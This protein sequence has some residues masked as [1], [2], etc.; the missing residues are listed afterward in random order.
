MSPPATW[1]ESAQVW[2]FTA[3]L[4]VLIVAACFAYYQ[5]REARRLREQQIRP[6]V[7]I[8]FEVEPNLIIYLE[9]TNLGNALARDV[10]IQ[11]DPPLKSAVDFDAAGLKM[12][13]EGITTLAPGK[14]Y[15][16]FFDQGNKRV[17][18]DLPMNYVAT[19]TYTDQDRKRPFEERL[20]LDLEQYE[21]IRFIKKKTLGDLTEQVEAVAKLLAKWNSNIGCGLIAMT[22][23]QARQEEGRILEEMEEG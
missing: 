11:I 9:V 7:V 4:V 1:A 5:V 3:Q 13:N 23:D 19:L 14:V 16:T 12:L 15:R 22:P 8:D 20:N 2:I 18:T 17:E 10:R 6:F 21:A